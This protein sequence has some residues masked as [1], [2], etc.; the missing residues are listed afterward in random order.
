MKLRLSE[1]AQALDGQLQGGDVEFDG[2]CTDTR[3][4]KPK[5]LFVAL[6]GDNFDG[7][8][9]LRKAASLGAAGALVDKAHD[10]DLPQVVIDDTLLGLQR[11]AAVWRAR[12]NMP[13]VGVTGSNGKTTVKELIAAVLGQNH[14][15]LATRGNLNNHIGVP[16][17][18]LQITPE[19]DFA[20]IEM[21][22]SHAGEI[23]LLNRLARPAVAVI[24]NAAGAHLEGFGSPEGVARAKGELFADLAA[25]GTAIIN[26]DDEYAPL[27]SELAGDRRQ[28]RFGLHVGADVS[29][30]AIESDGSST[31]FRLLTPEGEA[32]VELPL[33]GR[34]NVMN[35]LAAAAVVHAL[36]LPTPDIAYGLAQVKPVSGRLQ[37]RNA[38]IGARIVDD[39]YNANPASLAAALETLTHYSGESWLVLGDMGE[40]GENAEAAHA[41][42]GLAA[43]QAG[44]T[45]LYAVGPLSASAVTSFGEGG[46]HYAKQADLIEDLKAE[47]IPGITVLIKGSRTARMERVAAALEASNAPEGQ[48]C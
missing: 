42:A 30:R 2:V 7:H 29:A 23:A 5:Q 19:H 9:F 1:L 18:L 36:G 8:E 10:I 14:K 22:A 24:N 35:A 13:V 32:A 45:R 16:L 47:L 48:P 21:G 43:R 6:R 26:A 28:L 3:A 34:H 27:W 40:L 41:Q 46:R 25:D 33:T 37:I 38:A 31:R 17:T 12:F 11:G 20:V 15:V 4:L 39:S 44:V